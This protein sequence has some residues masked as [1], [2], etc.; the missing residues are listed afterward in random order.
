[1]IINERLIKLPK[2][3]WKHQSDVTYTDSICA[4]KWLTLQASRIIDGLSLRSSTRMLVYIYNNK[5]KNCSLSMLHCGRECNG[6]LVIHCNIRTSTI[7]VESNRFAVLLATANFYVIALI[8]F[9]YKH[10]KANTKVKFVKHQGE[11]G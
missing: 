6:S 2:V 5:S 3:Y 7:D 9:Y 4:G 10:K 8:P 1:L 11:R